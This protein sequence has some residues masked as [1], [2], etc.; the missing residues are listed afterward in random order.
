MHDFPYGESDCVELVE[1][2]RLRL[3]KCGKR[4][5]VGCQGIARG[6]GS[7]CNPAIDLAAGE[8]G[9]QQLAH[10]LF[11]RAQVFRHAGLE[12]KI[13][14]I[15]GLQLECKPSAGY[16]AAD[17]GKSG[18]ARDHGMSGLLSELNTGK[19]CAKRKG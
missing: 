7:E 17:G 18:H 15:N 4:V 16:L 13:T 6:D 1:Y 9:G 5:F 10:R 14:M 11:Q 19:K 12:L 3:G 8:L 2:L